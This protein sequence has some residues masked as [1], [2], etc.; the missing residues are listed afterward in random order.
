MKIA[1]TKEAKIGIVS[2]VSLVLLYVGI[3]YLK[4]IN[5]FKP[6]NHYYVAFN[7]VKGITISSPVYVEGFK[8]GLV[9]DIVYDY[10]T[11]GKI[12]VEVSFEEN[13]IDWFSFRIKYSVP[14]MDITMKIAVRAGAPQI[15]SDESDRIFLTI[16]SIIDNDRRKSYRQIIERNFEFINAIDYKNLD[17]DIKTP[18]M[19]NNVYTV[20]KI[21]ANSFEII[22]DHLIKWV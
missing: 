11:T 21:L 4:G 10:N 5:L 3:N 18:K 14:N 17:S 8:V 12:T 16:E 7:N 9:R 20:K 6:V 22:I 1:F 15:G 19:E 2:I 13:K